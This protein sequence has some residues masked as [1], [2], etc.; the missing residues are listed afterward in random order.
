M[1]PPPAW[2]TYGT[3]HRAAISLSVRIT[4]RRAIGIGEINPYFTWIDARQ[5]GRGARRSVRFWEWGIP[6][7]EPR[8]FGYCP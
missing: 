7:S 8:S 1:K 6:L 3:L 2:T 5:T 4:K